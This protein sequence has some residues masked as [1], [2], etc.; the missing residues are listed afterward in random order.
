MSEWEKIKNNWDISDL[1]NPLKK[2]IEDFLQNDIQLIQNNVHE[3]SISHHI[4]C[5][6]KKYI[7]E[8]HIDCEYNRDLLNTKTI[9]DMGD[10]RPDI[11]IHKR[12]TSNNFV[13]IEIKKNQGNS[14]H[15]FQKIKKLTERKSHYHYQWGIYLNIQSSNSPKFIGTIFRNGEIFGTFEHPD[16][17]DLIKQR[18]SF[19]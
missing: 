10:I 3:N 2:S 18:D 4:A 12:N 13:V 1:I 16:Y 19:Y 8:S 11:I 17:M 9:R 15:D 6:L 7:L 5:Y 14:N